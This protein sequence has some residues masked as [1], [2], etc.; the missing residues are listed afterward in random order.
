MIKK[1]R[2]LSAMAGVLCVVALAATAA[3]AFAAP[4]KTKAKGKADSGT[5]YAATTHSAGG[6]EYIAGQGTDKMFGSIASTYKAK[7]GA[8]ST[9]GTVKLTIKP[10]ILFTST[11]TLSGTSNATLT[12]VSTSSATVKGTLDLTKGT[13][14]LK[15][16]SFVGT[17]T[18][19]GDPATGVYVFHYKGTYK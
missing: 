11:G 7:V 9:V 8:G 13:G 6:F 3:T 19:T 12:V 17:V 10:V 1:S 18:G 5:V 16:H 15:G 2:A 4:S 14:A